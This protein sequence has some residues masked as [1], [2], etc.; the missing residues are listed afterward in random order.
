M[1]R[2]CWC[3]VSVAFLALIV[4]TYAAL[5]SPPRSKGAPK[6][7]IEG[8]AV[9]D[10]CA[11]AGDWKSA[12]EHFKATTSRQGLIAKYELDGTANSRQLADAWWKTVPLARDADTRSAYQAHAAALYQQA[13]CEGILEG[14]RKTVAMQRMAE[15]EKAGVCSRPDNM[16]RC[17][18]YCVI[19]L[20]AGPNAERYPVFYLGSEPSGGW[21]DEYKMRKLV[22]RRIEPGTF[23]M[24]ST[25]R[26]T[27]I[28][29]PY[30]IGVF[31]V[32]QYQWALVMGE[33]PSSMK[34]AKRPVEGVSFNT[35]RGGDVV[36]DAMSFV[37]RLRARAGLDV[38]LPNPERW[39]Y[40]CRAGTTSKFNNGCELESEEM[41]QLGRFYLNQSLTLPVERAGAS[42]PVQR[43]DGRG[44]FR[45]GHTAVGSYLPNNW[46]LYDLHGNVAEMCIGE[47]GLCV[48]RGG[49]W[50]DSES[51]SGM[52]FLTSSAWKTKP[53]DVRENWIGLRLI[54]ENVE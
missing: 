17:G 53:R 49:S 14:G 31:E 9:G 30:Y 52:C 38:D 21:A 34:G 6:G 29:K 46:R 11:V 7:G 12:L 36:A 48:L 27:T 15:A 22:L 23:V 42:G 41:W 51:R 13:L 32:T 33:N 5:G 16:V 24:G 47:D 40:A 45:T 39:E 18:R 2:L 10:A 35:V 50:A 26:R 19:D 20:S 3:K 44:G 1:E 43:P 25:G 37:G 4:G 8:L 54:A 28:V